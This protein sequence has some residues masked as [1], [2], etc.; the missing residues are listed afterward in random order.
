MQFWLNDKYCNINKYVSKRIGG[1]CIFYS[2]YL[3]VTETNFEID[4]NKIFCII[5]VNYIRLHFNYKL[6]I[7]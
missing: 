7:T 6:C 4:R 2:N 3:R 5:I 1:Q